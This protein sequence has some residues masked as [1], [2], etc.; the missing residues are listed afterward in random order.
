MGLG[1]GSSTSPL[2][3]GKRVGP[4]K[5][6]SPKPS[7]SHSWAPFAASLPAGGP[8]VQGSEFVP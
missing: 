2:I 5:H 4:D 6:L 7:S 1:S 3:L 8:G